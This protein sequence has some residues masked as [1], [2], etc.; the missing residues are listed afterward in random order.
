VNPGDP[1]SKSEL[2]RRQIEN[3]YR[4]RLIR[5]ASDTE[6]V[7]RASESVERIMDSARKAKKELDN[8]DNRI[9]D[10]VTP[11]VEIPDDWEDLPF[12]QLRALAKDLGAGA[13]ASKAQAKEFIKNAITS[14]EGDTE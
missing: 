11:N 10:I 6:Q 9:R 4:K 3:L 8:L 5:Q 1:I 12:L 2:S 7:R 14:N 13:I